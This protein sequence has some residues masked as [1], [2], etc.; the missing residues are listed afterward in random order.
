M[1][2]IGSQ[3]D[4]EE[5]GLVV[6]VVA[7][8]SL[9][10]PSPEV[11][12]GTTCNILDRQD[13]FVLPTAARHRMKLYSFRQLVGNFLPKEAA[14]LESIGA[15]GDDYLNL[16][17]L[18]FL[19]PLMPAMYCAKIFDI[20][21]LEGNKVLHRF[22]LAIISLCKDKLETHVITSAQEFWNHV[23]HYCN[24]GMDWAKVVSTAFAI[25]PS[26]LSKLS[27]SG[28][29]LTR[30]ALLRYEVMAKTALGDAL[31]KPLNLKYEE[32]AKTT[33]IS[34]VV[35]VNSLE[36][37]SKLISA[38]CGARLRM[39]LPEVMNME[40]FQLVFSTQE[41]GWSLSTLYA[42]TEGLYPC[43]LVIKTLTHNAIIGVYITAAISPPSGAVRGDGNSFI[44]R[45]DGPEAACYRWVGKIPANTR[46]TDNPLSSDSF[47]RSQ[48]GIFLSNSIMIGGSDIKGENAVHLNGDLSSCF[49]GASDTFGNGPLAPHDPHGVAMISDIEVLCGSRSVNQARA[50][51][52]LDMK[53]RMWSM[54]TDDDIDSFV[55]RRHG[56]KESSGSIKRIVSGE[57]PLT[58]NPVL[59]F[60]EGAKGRGRSFS[61][62]DYTALAGNEV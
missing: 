45:L 33:S 16:I 5:P 6:P 8:L 3:Y 13:W 43:L 58:E 47:T 19:L 26:A 62:S 55:R 59:G 52:A 42:K 53:S 27:A 21:L 60:V 4:L 20:F 15:L 2:L 51:G 9:F 10:I 36:G 14:I 39:F 7:M 31:H 22:G 11:V 37:V 32:T 17:F 61:G 49:F 12:F 50:S 48:F 41:D 1:L 25:G 54:D 29:S 46:S 24:S 38:S 34:N 30:A 57:S 35:S 40:G 56:D 18:D 28:T 44:C 23:R